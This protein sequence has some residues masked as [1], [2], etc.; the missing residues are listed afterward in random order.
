MNDDALARRW[1]VLRDLLNEAQRRRWAAIEAE[2][3]GP[4]GIQLVVRATGI[5]RQT[6]KQGLREL[7][8]H[9]DEGVLGPAFLDPSQDQRKP[10]GGRKEKFPDLATR[11]M[12]A[13]EQ[14]EPGNVW[15]SVILK[16]TCLSLRDIAA[17]LRGQHGQASPTTIS[18][19]LEGMGFRSVNEPWA[20][21]RL[22]LKARAPQYRAVARAVTHALD[23]A[24]PV[25][26]LDLLAPTEI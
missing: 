2:A 6:V 16:W 13:M 10:G 14:Q 9:R 3:L 5:A 22:P 23:A 21:R 12:A 17:Q 15:Q 1:A 19:Q 8:D 11:L 4:N 25:V 24:Q 20:P 26:V 7:Q 18:A